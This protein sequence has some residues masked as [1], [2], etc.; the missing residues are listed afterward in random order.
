[1]VS[2]FATAAALRADVLDMQN[3]DRYSGQVLAMTADNVLLR[4]EILGKI[5][6]PRNKVA[7]L[8]FG[9]NTA[10]AS[11]VHNPVPAPTLSRPA[12]S[13]SNTVDSLDVDLSTAL[14][15]LGSGTNFIGQIRGRMLAG[16]PEAAGKFDEMVGNLFSGQLTLNDLRRQAESSAAQLRALKHDLG[17][18]ADETLDGYLK[19]L[20]AFVKES[21]GPASLT[22]GP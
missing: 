20:D 12:A 15:Q 2:W 9:N 22:P 6:V 18:E 21:A 4:S 10:A 14:G 3:G 19:I 7:S 16:N 1:M 8:T 17:P 5:N 11:A 13:G